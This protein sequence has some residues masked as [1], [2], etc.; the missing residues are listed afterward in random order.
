MAIKYHPKV[1]EVL[2]CNFGQFKQPADGQSDPCNFDGRIPPE[3]IKQ[4]MVVILNGRLN[5]NCLVVPIS[6]KKDIGRI[7]QGLHVPL[8]PGLFR[9]TSFYDK[10]DRWAK[11]E[12]I[13]SV[14]LKRLFKLRDDH[15][16]FSHFLPRDKVTLIQRAV[17]KG[18]SA[19]ILINC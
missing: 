16:C 17:I 1:G 15:S 4:R 6:S 5:G 14:S 3:M 10:R 19:S 2:E 7:G 12:L 13:Q 8:A 11:A 18:I 9:I